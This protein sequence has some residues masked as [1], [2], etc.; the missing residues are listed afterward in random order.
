MSSLSESDEGLNTQQLLKKEKLK[1][2]KPHHHKGNIS[3]SVSATSV[4]SASKSKLST[5][6]TSETSVSKSKSKKST[7]VRPKTTEQEE[8]QSVVISDEEQEASRA[9]P[10][11]TAAEVPETIAVPGRKRDKRPEPY[12][13]ANLQARVTAIWT[14]L[15]QCARVFL[16]PEVPKI[17][18]RFNDVYKHL[19]KLSHQQ[20]QLFLAEVQWKLVVTFNSM[21]WKSLGLRWASPIERVTYNLMATLPQDIMPLERLN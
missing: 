19:C 15:Q 17:I 12:K 10:E 2:K 9:E 6:V 8:E 4:A 21:L 13:T 16:N 11:E 20:T 18:D 3:A 1:K 5:S 7:A 14:D